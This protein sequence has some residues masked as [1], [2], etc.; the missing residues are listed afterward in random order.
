M[1]IKPLN[2]FH[3][4]TAIRI[5]KSHPESFG[6][7]D[8]ERDI[9]HLLASQMWEVVDDNGNFMGMFGLNRFDKKE[10][11][12]AEIVFA[13]CYV[14]KKYRHKGVFNAMIEFAKKET[15]KEREELKKWVY[16]TLCCEKNNKLAYDI[17]N[18]KFEFECYNKKDK[19]YWWTI[20]C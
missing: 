6:K 20:K 10:S 12:F 1:K 3:R 8:A 19:I 15:I 2:Q 18:R 17:Y 9:I 16:L 11:N 14:L 4:R 5:L 13:N 7:F